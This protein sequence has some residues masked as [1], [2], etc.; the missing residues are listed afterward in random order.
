MA[1]KRKRRAS[2]GSKGL[3]PGEQLNR[4]KLPRK[5]TSAWSWVGTEASA[6]P[7]IN[8]EHVLATCGLSQRS[9]H[10]FCANRLAVPPKSPA[11]NRDDEIG[12][13][14]LEDD[15]IVVSDNEDPPCS[16]K[17]CKANPNCLNYLGQDVWEDPG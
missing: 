7:E 12:N 17:L 14:E 1:P 13:G 16:K 6:A 2:P 11:E 8:Q 3:N 10:N 9:G 15:V 4:G 5:T